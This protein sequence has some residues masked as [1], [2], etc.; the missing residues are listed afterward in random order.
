MS[1]RRI[2]WIVSGRPAAGIIR[3]TVPETQGAAM[4]V[5]DLTQ[6]RDSPAASRP[7]GSERAARI[8]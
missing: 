1:A 7:A 6:R 8:M 2:S 4:L 3:A 5:P